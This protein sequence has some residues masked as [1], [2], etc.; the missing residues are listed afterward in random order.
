MQVRVR[1]GK[2]AF[3]EAGTP[4]SREGSL[5]W[6]FRFRDSH[7][8]EERGTP[9]KGKK[10]GSQREERGGDEPRRGNWDWEL[11]TENWTGST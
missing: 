3:P 11:G 1:Q 9:G 8:S 5:G 10:P 4:P 2:G 6:E 7:I